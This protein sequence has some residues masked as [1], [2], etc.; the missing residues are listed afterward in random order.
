MMA[1]VDLIVCCLCV[2]TMVPVVPHATNED[3]RKR[4]QNHCKGNKANKQFDEKVIILI[5]ELADLRVAAIDA[6]PPRVKERA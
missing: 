6:R 5:D 4:E 1:I 2:A 3:Q